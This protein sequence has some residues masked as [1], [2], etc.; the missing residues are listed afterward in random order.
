MGQGGTEGVERPGAQGVCGSAPVSFLEA[1]L[2]PI[3]KGASIVLDTRCLHCG[4]PGD[5]STD[6]RAHAYGTVR[7]SSPAASCRDAPRRQKDYITTVD[8]LDA[9]NYPVGT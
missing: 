2:V 8:I 3:S 1:V 5:E 4:G 6:F 9:N 7:D